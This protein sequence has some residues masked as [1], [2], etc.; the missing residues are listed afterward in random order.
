[1]G[2][3][4]VAMLDAILVTNTSKRA[5]RASMAFETNLELIWWLTI[6]WPHLLP[7]GPC[8]NL[9]TSSHFLFGIDLVTTLDEISSNGLHHGH[10]PCNANKVNWDWGWRWS[11]KED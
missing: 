11:P 8:K 9:G 6:Y 5:N 3:T 4:C 1:V 10:M 2:F 7:S